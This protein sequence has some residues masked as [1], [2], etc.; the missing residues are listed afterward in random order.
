MNHV[1]S[2]GERCWAGGAQGG[3]TPL[4]IARREAHGQVVKLLLADERVDRTHDS[5]W[6]HSGWPRR[7]VD[8][9]VNLVNKFI[10]GLVILVANL[11][12]LC[13][14]ENLLVGGYVVLWLAF[15]AI[16]PPF[17]GWMLAGATLVFVV[18]VRDP[19]RC[20]AFAVCFDSARI[21]LTRCLSPG[22]A[23]VQASRNTVMYSSRRC[24]LD[25]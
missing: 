2:G 4:F 14:C 1:D 21:G 12:N 20:S 7:A 22:V 8:A 24:S 23:S 10:A 25:G 19:R 16:L 11:V 17:L 5:S 6:P 3:V 9:C 13:T 15:L 18:P